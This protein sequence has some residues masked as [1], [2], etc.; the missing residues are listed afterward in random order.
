M[1][2]RFRSVVAAAVAATSLTIPAAEAYVGLGRVAPARPRAV[3]IVGR[4]WGHGRGMGQWGAHGMARAGSGWQQIVRHYYRGARISSIRTDALIRVA[5]SH[6]TAVTLTS[7]RAMQ[8]RW[9]G[10]HRTGAA[11]HFYRFRRA[12]SG[13]II[14]EASRSGGPFRRIASATGTVRVTGHMIATAGRAGSQR[15]YRGSFILQPDARTFTVVN[16]VPLEQYLRGV[17]PREMPSV[18]PTQA[19]AAQAVAART[20]AQR[21]RVHSRANHRSV[22]I[23]D[24]ARCQVYGGAA[25]RD[26]AGQPWRRLET[27]RT[28]SVIAHTA[29]RILTYRGHAILAE[30]SSS[31]GGST[32]NGGQPYLRPVND[33]ADR[34][35]PFHA[36]AREVTASEIEAAFPDIGSFRG[37]RVTRRSHHRIEAITIIGSHAAARATGARF[38]ARLGLRSRWFRVGGLH[39]AAFKRTLRF[40]AHGLDVAALQLRL[41]AAGVYP[42]TAPVTSYFGPITRSALR[43]FQASHALRGTGVLDRATR[44]VLNRRIAARRFVRNMGFGDTGTDVVRLQ[45]L[46]RAAGYFPRSV[47]A[48]GYFGPITRASVRRYQRAHHLPATGYVGV[49]TRAKLNR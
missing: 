30:Y 1:C 48:T 33:P 14:G 2:R 26:G 39:T 27:P 5:L 42:R 40:G 12:A 47:D 35:S 41:R 45:R 18:W 13:V 20:Y 6:R 16:S 8:I 19:I 46:L 31:T 36:W 21:V 28:D 11:R 7:T 9:G 32:I 24:D 29:G 44:R 22:D 25:R 17:V 3:M 10:H 38:Q 43:R 34:I 23:C 15:A 49:R 4:G 37:L